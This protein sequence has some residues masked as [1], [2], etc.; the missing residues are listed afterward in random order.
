MTLV[1]RSLS[2]MFASTSGIREEIRLASLLLLCCN[3]CRINREVISRFSSLT[4]WWI[5]SS[6]WGCKNSDILKAFSSVAN[7][8]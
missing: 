7:C 5:K 2:V 6:R 1:K 3:K 8:F 4:A